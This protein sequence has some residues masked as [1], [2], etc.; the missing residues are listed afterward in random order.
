MNRFLNWLCKPLCEGKDDT[1][2][3]LRTNLRLEKDISEQRLKQITL[4]E[5]TND[6]LQKASNL[7]WNRYVQMKRELE[8]LQE[9]QFKIPDISD[10]VGERTLISNSKLYRAGY[11]W[12]IA[13]SSYYTFSHYTW[14]LIMDRVHEAVQIQLIRWRPEIGDCDNW[15]AITQAFTSLAFAETDMDYQGAIA[16]AW[17]RRHAYNV[18]VTD[19]LEFLLFE[20]QNDSW[21]GVLYDGEYDDSYA[22]RKL[23]FIT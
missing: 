8:S 12:H 13:D 14:G 15:G 19:E 17:S 4:L 3:T 5:E 16:I 6:L 11:E 7:Y 23:F 1:I 2:E 22:T 9:E 10:L 20:P 18:V 21:K